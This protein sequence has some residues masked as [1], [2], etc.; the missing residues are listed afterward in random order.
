MKNI[1][2]DKNVD[3]PKKNRNYYK[4][5]L[6]R[7]L[8]KMSF[9]NTISY[10]KKIPN[11]NNSNKI[12]KNISFSYYYSKYDKYNNYFKY[13]KRFINDYNYNN[14]KGLNILNKIINIQRNIIIKQ[15]EKE[16]KLKEKI[17][18]LKLLF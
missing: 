5:N 2:K 9:E 1:K 13:N 7:N 8:K 17:N 4:C 3:L 15:K 16:E 11:K 14:I 6:F 18:N 12:C 10:K